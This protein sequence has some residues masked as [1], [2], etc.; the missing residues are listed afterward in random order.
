M[1]RITF[2][3]VSKAERLAL[4]G[5]IRLIRA[6]L[7]SCEQALL[8]TQAAPREALPLRPA[9]TVT[10]LAQARAARVKRDA[11]PARANYMEAFDAL[12]SG[13]I[14]EYT[15]TQKTKTAFATKSIYGRTNPD[16]DIDIIK[17]PE[18]STLTFRCNQ[19]ARG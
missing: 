14:D 12:R 13:A 7:G 18:V 16:I 19:V 5:A 3:G 15:I 1:A 17:G 10:D 9:A 2:N 11:A 4:L 6:M 8:G